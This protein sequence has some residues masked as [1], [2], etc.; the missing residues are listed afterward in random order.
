[1]HTVLKVMVARYKACIRCEGDGCIDL[2]HAYCCEGD[3]VGWVIS[4][5]LFCAI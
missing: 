3:S 1:M 4:L 5:E 2:K